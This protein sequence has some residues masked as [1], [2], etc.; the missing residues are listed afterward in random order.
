VKP[1]LRANRPV[2]HVG[3]V[4]DVLRRLPSDHF[5]CVITSPPYYGLRDYKTPPQVWG[6]VLDCPH[7]WGDE[8]PPLHKGQVEQT[9]WAKAEGHGKGGNATTG[10]FCQRCGAWRGS[11]GLEPTPHLFVE[12]LVDVFREVRRVLRPDG[13]AWVNL[14]DSYA[15]S[16]KGAWKN[17][18][19]PRKHVYRPLAAGPEAAQPKSWDGIKPKDIIGIPW[20]VALALQADGWWLRQDIVW[21]LS[22][23]T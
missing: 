11:L 13:L 15:G 8:M 7:Q 12:H 3:H 5:H 22:G 9:K 2:L 18:E 17:T 4:L 19:A 21:C 23:G 14:G 6:G 20:R 16:G 1:T 10:A